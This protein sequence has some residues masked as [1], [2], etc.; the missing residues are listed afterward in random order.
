M[1]V[2][3]VGRKKAARAR[4]KRPAYSLEGGVSQ[5]RVAE[6][7]HCRRAAKFNLD[8]W[9]SPTTKE[10]LAFGGLVHELNEGLYE[11]VRAGKMTGEPAQ[12]R[13]FMTAT[14]R[15]WRKKAAGWTSPAEAQTVEKC[16]AKATAVYPGYCAKWKKDFDPK[17]WRELE[18]EFDVE[19]R[20]FRLKGRIDG[21]LEVKGKLW[22]L[23]TKTMGRI[24]EALSD[25][26]GFDFQTLFYITAAEVAVGR[27][28]EGAIYNVIRRPGHKQKDGESLPKFVARVA[29]E[30]EKKPDHFFK[31]FELTYSPHRRKIFEAELEMKLN[32]F[33]AWLRD[34]GPT[35]R[36]ERSCRGRYNC[37]W[38]DACSS[39]SMSGY[40]TKA[41]R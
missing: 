35:W 18:G 3:R 20:G 12:V 32:A 22:I 8:G 6:F 1:G 40:V 5:T 17:I 28:V 21:I 4:P 19:W 39:G 26:L 41:G 7:V 23:E 30:V 9:A 36:D 31:R 11:R 37:D 2:R 29:K 27:P 13:R 10:S 16:V 33:G 38:L 24:D 15:A 14:F 25:S 34:G